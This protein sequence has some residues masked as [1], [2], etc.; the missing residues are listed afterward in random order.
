M[1]DYYRFMGHSG[2]GLIEPIAMIDD[3]VALY[4][5]NSWNYYKVSLYEAIPWFQFLNL[6]A[7]AANTV[8][9]LVNAGNL[10][11]FDE[12][13][14]QFRWFPIDNAQVLRRHPNI[15]TNT[16]RNLQ[17]P[18]DMN[19]VD[20]DPCLHLTE[21]FVFEDERPQF[22]AINGAN[23]A[24]AQCRLVGGGFRFGINRMDKDQ[25]AKLRRDREPVTPIV[26]QGFGGSGQ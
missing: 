11:M 15:T 3:N 12:E 26:C 2:L 4:K 1:S 24:L 22:Q 20:R 16:L 9:G 8:G 7:V 17:V 21:F 23:I 25:I 18:I 13:F 19:I 5:G 10:D 14:G 6:G